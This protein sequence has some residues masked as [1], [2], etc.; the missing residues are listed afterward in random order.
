MFV[1]CVLCGV[2]GWMGGVTVHGHGRYTRIYRRLTIIV[3]TILTSIQLFGRIR[4]SR[5][6]CRYEGYLEYICITLVLLVCFISNLYGFLGVYTVQ[7]TKWWRW[8]VCFWD[9][10]SVYG[11]GHHIQWWAEDIK[12]I[13]RVL[14]CTFVRNSFCVF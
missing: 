5:Y 9:I 10:F 2:W 3:Q 7:P 8:V 11:E 6:V 4:S 12:T 1:V 14:F 13:L